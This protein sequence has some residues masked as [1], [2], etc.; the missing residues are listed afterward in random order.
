MDTVVRVL[1]SE[2]GNYCYHSYNRRS[3]PSHWPHDS[4]SQ[5]VLS[6]PGCSVRVGTTSDLSTP[7]SLVP[8]SQLIVDVQLS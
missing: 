8:H 3:V 5:A 1:C 4:T 2:T 6:F 7:A